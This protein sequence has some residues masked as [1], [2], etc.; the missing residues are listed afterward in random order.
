MLS[1][2]RV[3][4]GLFGGGVGTESEEHERALHR[5]LC[6]YCLL[7]HLL[8]VSASRLNEGRGA[9]NPKILPKFPKPYINQPETL[10]SEDVVFERFHAQ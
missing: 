10:N 2:S 5:Y 4:V 1:L 3:C 7:G 9:A 8:L 6:V